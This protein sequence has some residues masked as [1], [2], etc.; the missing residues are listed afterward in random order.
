MSQQPPPE[1]GALFVLEIIWLQNRNQSKEAKVKERE[2]LLGSRGTSQNLAARS[3]GPVWLCLF[4]DAGSLTHWAGPGTE[5]EHP[6]LCFLV[7]MHSTHHGSPCS[8]FSLLIYMTFLPGSVEQI[9]PVSQSQCQ[10][11]L[12]SSLGLMS[13]PANCGWPAWE[14]C[15]LIES[16]PPRSVPLA[17]TSGGSR[18][19]KRGNPWPWVDANPSMLFPTPN[20]P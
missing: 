14:D 4:S 6:L 19:F 2:A 3:T 9:N 16:W 5:P 11:M 10:E 18:C 15:G 1:T 13:T 17:G 12:I 20:S 7:H 8:S